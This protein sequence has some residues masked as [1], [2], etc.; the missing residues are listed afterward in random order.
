MSNNRFTISEQEKSEIKKLY[1]LNEQGYQDN[2]LPKKDYNLP[3]SPEFRGGVQGTPGKIT[4]KFNDATTTQNL[5]ASMFLNGVDTID[6]NSE[7]FK[8]ALYKIKFIL[9]YAKGIVPVTIKGGA[10]SVGA[11]KGYDNT[12]LANRRRDNFIKALKNSLGNDFSRL[13]ITSGDAIIGGATEKNSPKANA[14]QIVQISYPEKMGI[15]TGSVKDA[16]DSTDVASRLGQITPNRIE[17]KVKIDPK[18]QYMIVKIWYKGDKKTFQDKI[19]NST[20]SPVHELIDYETAKDLR[21]K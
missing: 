6:T 17:D 5:G 3:K 18:A 9:K 19:F 13:N 12:G 21:F 10:S 7:V 1:V 16:I 4:Y 15:V 8:N 20:G 2:M 11:S 14:E